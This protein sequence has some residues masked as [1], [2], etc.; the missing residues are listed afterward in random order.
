LLGQLIPDVRR[1][2]NQEPYPQKKAL[3]KLM[4]KHVSS[5]ISVSYI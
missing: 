5:N 2:Q 3:K 1:S 4:V